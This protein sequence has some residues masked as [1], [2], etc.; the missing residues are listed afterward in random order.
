[1]EEFTAWQEQVVGRLRSEL[2]RAQQG[3]HHP[4]HSAPPT[5]PTEATDAGELFD[6]HVVKHQR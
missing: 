1:M 4:P 2:E 3:H 6:A 5:R